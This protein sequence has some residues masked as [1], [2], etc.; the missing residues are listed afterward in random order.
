MQRNAAVNNNNEDKNK[1]TGYGYID[2]YTR[3]GE[4]PTGETPTGET[5]KSSTE[6]SDADRELGSTPWS[7]KGFLGEGPKLANQA[8][9]RLLEEEGYDLRGVKDKNRLAADYRLGRLNK[10]DKGFWYENKFLR[11]T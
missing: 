8:S 11:N 10:T 3:P 4:T 1:L 6:I 5:P 2:P 9:W 7:R